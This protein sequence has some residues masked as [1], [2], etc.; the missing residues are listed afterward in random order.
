MQRIAGNHQ[1]LEEAE[2]DAPLEPP[3]ERVPADILIS[4][5]QPP[6]T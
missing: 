1:M 2:K 3:A 4:D 6:E 5:F